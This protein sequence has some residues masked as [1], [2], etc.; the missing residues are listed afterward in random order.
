MQYPFFAFISRMRYIQRWGLMR[1]SYQENS[2]EHS[3]MMAV[4]TRRRF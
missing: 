4:T 2:Q 3:H 1:N